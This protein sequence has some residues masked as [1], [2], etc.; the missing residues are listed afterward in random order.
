[1][2]NQWDYAVGGLA[3]YWTAAT[4][5]YFPLYLVGVYQVHHCYLYV[6]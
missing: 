1:M 6:V 3:R 5:V 4:S 2:V